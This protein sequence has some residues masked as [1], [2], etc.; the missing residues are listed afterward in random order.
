MKKKLLISFIGIIV[1]SIIVF[2]TFIFM[3]KYEPTPS[4]RAVEK[5]VQVNNLEEFGDV[6]GPFLYTPKNYG[7][8][9]DNNIFI[10]EKFLG[11]KEQYNNQYV[12]INP[13][14]E[15]TENDQKLVKEIQISLGIEISFGIES[16][17]IKSKHKVIVYKNGEKVIEDWFFKITST[18]NDYKYLS[19]VSPKQDNILFLNF[20]TKGYETFRDF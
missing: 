1:L 6:E 5:M 7:Y 19:F 8:Y 4:K 17:N 16:Y 15:I 12:V 18:Y 9:N 2:L 3:F 11:R 13:A 20:F 14:E 10:V